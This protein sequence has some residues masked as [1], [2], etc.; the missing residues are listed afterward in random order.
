MYINT[1][2]IELVDFFCFFLFCFDNLV[3]FTWNMVFSLCIYI[4]KEEA[5]TSIVKLSLD[6]TLDLTFS[7][8][9]HK[10]FR[11]QSSPFFPTIRTWQLIKIIQ[12]SAKGVL[13]LELTN[14]AED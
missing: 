3:H 6:M 14:I 13:F 4:L 8:V 10:S 12:H 9:T 7:V 5:L 11:K 1:A 2:V